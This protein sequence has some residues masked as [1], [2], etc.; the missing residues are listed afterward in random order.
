MPMTDQNKLS[1]SPS[2]QL[3]GAQVARDEGLASAVSAYLDGEL[4]G[5]E[6]A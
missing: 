5:D 3:G 1:C 4:M 6:L 2:A